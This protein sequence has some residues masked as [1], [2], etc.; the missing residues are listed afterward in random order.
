[1]TLTGR[2][3]PSRIISYFVSFSFVRCF[4][5]FSE[6]LLPRHPLWICI[7]LDFGEVH[8]TLFFILSLPTELRM[9]K[10]GTFDLVEQRAFEFFFPVVCPCPFTVHPRAYLLLTLD[11][12]IHSPLYRVSPLL[13][14]STSLHYTGLLHYTSLHNAQCS[15]LL[16]HK[17]RITRFGL[18]VA[19]WPVTTMSLLGLARGWT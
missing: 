5:Y 19:D 18:F 6:A 8:V 12:S 3:Q 7:S 13:I 15:P 1:M 11:A 10:N 16:L 17:L 2:C 14:F 4:F 9:A